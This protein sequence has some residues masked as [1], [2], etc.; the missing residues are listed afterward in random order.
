MLEVN[1]YQASPLKDAIFE[2]IRKTRTDLADHT[3]NQLNAKVY[4]VSSLRLTY[5]G[6]LILKKVF[7]A[8][9]F[10]VDGHLKGKH[11]LG[12]STLVSPYYV[13]G[14]RF[15]VFSRSDALAVKLSGGVIQYLENCFEQRN[16]K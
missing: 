8:Y 15:I 4:Y 13:T 11:Y 5:H 10:E 1:N 14:K 6:F 3:N 7:T 12:M 16:I 9:S 2:E